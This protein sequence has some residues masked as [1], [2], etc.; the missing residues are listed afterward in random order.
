MSD[1]E[2]E[3]VVNLTFPKAHATVCLQALEAGKHV[4]VEKPLAVTREEG[5]RV[6]ELAVQR[7]ARRERAGDVPRRRH[8]NLPEADRRRRDRAADLDI[9]L[10][11]G[12]RTGGM[13][14]GSGVFL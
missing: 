8:P 3:I 13:A 2:I 7:A 6:L 5:K 14:S 1:P 10:H 11:D 12:R 9:G 4:Y